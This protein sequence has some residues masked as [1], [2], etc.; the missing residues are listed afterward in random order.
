MFYF[1]PNN[2]ANIPDDFFRD[3]VYGDFLSGAQGSTPTTPRY[4]L[5]PAETSLTAETMDTGSGVSKD[6]FPSFG[7]KKVHLIALDLCHIKAL[8][9]EGL[10][11]NNQTGWT[12]LKKGV[13]TMAK[14]V[15]KLKEKYP[16]VAKIAVIVDKG[17]PQAKRAVLKIGSKKMNN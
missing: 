6:L 12:T 7:D 1:D 15:S 3:A 9:A 16:D 14:F 4:V 17:L 5:V 11:I 2:K 13:E 10:L 8:H